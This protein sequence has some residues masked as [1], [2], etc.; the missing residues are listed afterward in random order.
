MTPETLLQVGGNWVLAAAQPVAKNSALLDLLLVF[1]VFAGLYVIWYGISTS[2]PPIYGQ[3]NP[4]ETKTPES[5]ADYDDQATRTR[6]LARKLE[7]DAELDE[8]RLKAALK[9]DELAEMEELIGRART[10][11]SASGGPLG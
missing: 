11:R 2:G 7:A 8:A 4:S 5:A 9:K 1:G 10:K 6:A 3:T